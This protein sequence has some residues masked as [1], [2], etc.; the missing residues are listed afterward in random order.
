[1]MTIG[2]KWTLGWG[3][4]V[5][6]ATSLA[7]A[8]DD[9]ARYHEGQDLLTK[10]IAVVNAISPVN[11]PESRQRARALKSLAAAQAQLNCALL[12]EANPKAACH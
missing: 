12:R 4:A 10:A 8:S 2:R 3:V 6:F 11:R 7:L 5:M 1:M 9:S